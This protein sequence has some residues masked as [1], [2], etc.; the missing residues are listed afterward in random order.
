MTDEKLTQIFNAC[1][2]G[3]G[4]DGWAGAHHGDI[5][6]LTGGDTI[7]VRQSDPDGPWTVIPGME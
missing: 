5:D 2:K 3:Q 4:P 6:S 7:W 1:L